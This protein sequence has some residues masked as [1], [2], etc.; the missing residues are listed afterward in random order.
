MENITSYNINTKSEEMSKLM[1]SW[2]CRNITPLGRITVL[3][4]LILSKI[5][6]ILQSLPSPDQSTLKEIDKKNFDFIWRKKRHE[7]NKI[8]LCQEWQNGGLN[9]INLQEFDMSLKITWL[10]KLSSAD[11]EWEEFAR[12]YNAD[13]FI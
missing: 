6:H 1:H 13:Q 5:I 10:R 7:V 2:S 9:M 11:L 4:S 3:K 8:T 12:H